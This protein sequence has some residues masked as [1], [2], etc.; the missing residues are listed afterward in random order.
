MSETANRF[1]RKPEIPA[2]VVIAEYF[3]A[4]DAE[5][6][7]EMALLADLDYDFSGR[8]VT[9]YFFAEDDPRFDRWMKNRRSTNALFLDMCYEEEV[10]RERKEDE[11][12]RACED[13]DAD[14]YERRFG[15]Y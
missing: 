8:F 11:Y 5:R 12:D 1:C 6:A 3:E 13:A 15:S 2:Q 14:R 10:E 9:P 4:M 7:D